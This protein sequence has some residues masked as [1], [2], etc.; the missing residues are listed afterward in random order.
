MIDEERG[1]LRDAQSGAVRASPVL[2]T[3]EGS[4]NLSAGADRCAHDS[5]QSTYAHTHG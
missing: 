1:K 3:H 2:Q 4:N 5:R